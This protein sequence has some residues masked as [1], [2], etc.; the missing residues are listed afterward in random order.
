M[1]YYMG[2]IYIENKEEDLRK[3]EDINFGG[4]PTIPDD[5]KEKISDGSWLT[6]EI[7]YLET[8]W[9]SQERRDILN[10]G[11]ALAIKKIINGTPYDEWVEKQ[12]ES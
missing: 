8:F 6:F 1:A 5:I 10:T 4:E 3:L 2:F 7:K 9:I 12:M 11:L